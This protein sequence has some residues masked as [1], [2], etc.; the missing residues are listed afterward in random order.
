M[1]LGE[2]NAT[3]LS[4]AAN[5]QTDENRAMGYAIDRQM[6]NLMAFMEH[7]GVWSA[8]DKVDSRY[9]DY[10]A[11]SIRA[12]YYSSADPGYKKCI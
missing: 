2:E 12:P 3:F 4:F 9:Y 5:F 8:L 1:R 6:A 7:V 11:A 10:I